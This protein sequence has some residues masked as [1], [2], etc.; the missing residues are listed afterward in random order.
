MNNSKNYPKL[1]MVQPRFTSTLGMIQTANISNQ[2]RNN[3]G[4][5]TRWQR[6]WWQ[7]YPTP[8]QRWVLRRWWQLYPIPGQ[9]WVLERWWQLYPIPGQ[10]WGLR[11]WCPPVRG[12]WQLLPL[13]RRCDTPGTAPGGQR[14]RPSST[15]IMQEL[16]D[17]KNSKMMV[18]HQIH[19]ILHLSFRKSDGHPISMLLKDFTC[20]LSLHILEII[21]KSDSGAGISPS[22]LTPESS[23]FKTVTSLLC[24]DP[25]RA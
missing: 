11:R 22:I 7:L 20:N 12:W 19:Q 16:A 25:N 3:I 1:G 8:G 10:R 24:I 4:T 5:G 23:F 14:R 6:G 9:R 2:P 18:Q 13:C 21:N 15:S 17:R